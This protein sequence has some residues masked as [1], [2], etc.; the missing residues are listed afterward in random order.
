MFGK[1]ILAACV[2]ALSVL[3]MSAGPTVPQQA[4]DAVFAEADFRQSMTRYT[5]V[6][7]ADGKIYEIYINSIGLDGWRAERR[8][9]MGSIFAIESFLA[10]RN[11]DGSLLRDAD[12]RLV[13]GASEN[14][15]HVSEK[16]AVWPN[17]NECTSPSLM[18]GRPMGEGLWR[19]A[20]FD[21]R[22]GNRIAE[23]TQT[24]GE[25]HQCH[26]DR[27]GEDF[28]LSRGL[29]DSFARSDKP[30]YISFTCGE[31]DICFG[32]PPKP[33]SSPLPACEATFPR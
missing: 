17:E 2:A 3:A 16:R 26:N 12:G 9:P 31:R 5:T 18:Q 22:N 27:R 6:D 25:C 15:I 4:S 8:L 30:S 7:R 29:L 21:G 28:I 24:P 32:G 14:E 20:A 13:K 11:A 23:A 19:M 10:E 33:L 1:R